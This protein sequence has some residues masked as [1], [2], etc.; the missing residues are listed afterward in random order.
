MVLISEKQTETGQRKQ[1]MIRQCFDENNKQAETRKNQKGTY[2]SLNLRPPKTS[3]PVYFF[4][5]FVFN[6]YHVMF[7]IIERF[8]S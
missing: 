6:I 7:N 2:A 4:I 1:L 5:K 8:K 3:F